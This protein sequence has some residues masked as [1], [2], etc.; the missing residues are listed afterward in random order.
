MT[1]PTKSQ[2]RAL[3]WLKNRGGEGVFNKHNVLLDQGELA[4]VMRATWNTLA[5]DGL[6]IYSANKSAKRVAIT[7]NGVEVLKSYKGI[8]AE[9][10]DEDIDL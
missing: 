7:T 4:G 5:D 10:V 2:L 8:E 6:V 3:L 1:A 9:T